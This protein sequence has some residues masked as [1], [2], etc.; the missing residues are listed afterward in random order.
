MNKDLCKFSKIERYC[1]VL[2][3][4]IE[5][6]MGVRYA[7]IQAYYTDLKKAGEEV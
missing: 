2:W 3:S 4:R 7:F 6:C 1:E 5:R